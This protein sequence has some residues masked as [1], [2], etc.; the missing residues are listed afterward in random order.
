[1]NSCLFF[2]VL[3][4]FCVRFVCFVVPHYVSSSFF[5]FDMFSFCHTVLHFGHLGLFLNVLY[6]E[7]LPV[8]VGWL[9]YNC[10]IEEY[11]TFLNSAKKN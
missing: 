3:I 5:L 2:S 1:M 9:L 6:E 7:I 10:I 8:I 11:L 4:H